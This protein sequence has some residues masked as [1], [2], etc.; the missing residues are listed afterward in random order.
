MCTG[1]HE[2][3]QKH[4]EYFLD[5]DTSGENGNKNEKI[6]LKKAQAKYKSV[7]CKTFGSFPKH[8][9]FV[10]ITNGKGYALGAG[11]NM[12]NSLSDAEVAFHSSRMWKKGEPYTIIEKHSF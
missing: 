7:G 2:F 4:Q 1:A 11:D 8:G 9:I 10:I 3:G 6:V 5:W 12:K